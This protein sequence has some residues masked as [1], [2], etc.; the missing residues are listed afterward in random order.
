[1]YGNLGVQLFFII[2]GFV[3]TLTLTKSKTFL[4][5]MKK[6]FLRLIPGMMICATVT[7]LVFLLFDSYDLNP[8]SKDFYNL[9]LSYTFISPLLIN[10]V[11]NTDLQYIDGAYWS[12]W[13]E[14]QF[15]VLAG[16]TYFLSPKN[17]LRNYSIVSLL[18]LAAQVLF[19]LLNES[20]VAGIVGNRMYSHVHNL[21][22]VF[23]LFANNLW[24]LSGVVIYKMY[25]GK[26]DVK[27]L[28]F[29]LFIFLI[30]L[31]LLK[32]NY[33]RLIGAGIIS[34]FL[35][36]LYNQS[37]IRFLAN[38]ML[39]KIGVASYSIYLIHQFI[40][41]LVVNRLTP[42]FGDFNWIIGIVLIIAFTIFGLLSY[43]YL[44][45]PFGDVLRK[46]MFKNKQNEQ[47]AASEAPI[48]TLP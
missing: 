2:S 4:E 16:L 26:K 20:S 3:I 48:S 34:L 8:D 17:F 6:R 41:F 24:F 9:L 14:L 11:L 42:Y 10:S 31:V 1:M 39:S 19:D 7:Y 5:F 30:Q 45:K 29:L 27:Q 32:D 35:L 38:D 47:Q 28:A 25:Y 13:V 44:E 33:A 12:L 21:L 46:M 22:N 43:K 37:M 40:G 18:G 15:Y 23:P 36:F